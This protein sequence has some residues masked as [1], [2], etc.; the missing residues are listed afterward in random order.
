MSQVR[1]GRGASLP[2]SLLVLALTG[3][4]VFHVGRTSL[5]GTT[6]LADA[7]KPSPVDSTFDGCGPAGAQPDYALNRR[8]NRVDD[9]PSYLPVAWTM[10]ARLPWP[11]WAGY[12]FRN[13]WTRKETRDVARFEG[14]AV[15]VEGY[16]AGYRL[17]VP[18][19][20]NC[21]ARDARHKDFHL[22]L[23]Q[24]P[25]GTRRQGIVVELTPR[26]R[27]SHPGW[28]DERLLA[29]RESRAR[30]RVR[31]WLMLDQM[32]PEKVERNRRTLWEVHPV[33]HLDWRAAD[34]RWVPLDSLEPPAPSQRP[35]AAAAR[36]PRR[37]RAHRV[38]IANSTNP[39]STVTSPSS[40]KPR[41]TR[42][43]KSSRPW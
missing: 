14:T 19:P 28:T 15:A 25:G 11:T 13:Q 9:A 33:M 10:I 27:A 37:S 17:E 6:A 4:G 5:E 3:C 30:V 39:D 26:V 43:L 1:T 36:R 24:G 23:S 7:P 16:L 29:L 2:A 12:R 20:P 41:S 38:V 40:E 35:I 8:K 31:G 32:H 22:W 21:Y 18:E 42:L 34:G